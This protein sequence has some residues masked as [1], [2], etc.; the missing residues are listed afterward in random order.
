MS[1]DTRRGKMCATM[2]AMTGI[3]AHEIENAYQQAR[4]IPSTPMQAMKQ[5][6]QA[7]QMMHAYQDL[8]ISPPTH[9]VRGPKPESHA[10]HAA[11][12][13][14]L[15]THRCP[16]CKRFMGQA[17]CQNCPGIRIIA[18][19]DMY[20]AYNGKT[21]IMEGATH[22]IDRDGTITID[23]MQDGVVVRT[24]ATPTWNTQVRINE[25]VQGVGDPATTTIPLHG[26]MRSVGVWEA[27]PQQQTLTFVDDETGEMYIQI[28]TRTDTEGTH[29]I[30]DVGTGGR[31]ATTQTCDWLDD[32]FM[33][34]YRQGQD[35]WD[36]AYRHVEETDQ[37]YQILLANA[38][39]H[40]VQSRD[41]AWDAF[42]HA[43][44]I[45]TQHGMQYLADGTRDESV[46]F[47]SVYEDLHADATG[48]DLA[49]AVHTCPAA[50]AV[51][52]RRMREQALDKLAQQV[53]REA[54]SMPQPVQ[55][56][57][58]PTEW[59][60][61]QAYFHEGHIAS[62]PERSGDLP[63]W[64][65]ASLAHQA[66]Q[67]PERL[68]PATVSPMPAVIAHQGGARNRG[69]PITWMRLQTPEVRQDIINANA[70]E[71]YNEQRLLDALGMASRDEGRTWKQDLA[72]AE[73]QYRESISHDS[74]DATATTL[75]NEWERLR[76]LRHRMPYRWRA[77][78]GSP[79]GRQE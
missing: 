26:G 62:N 53:A 55:P 64:F 77:P 43:R 3:P 47:D 52:T 16:N 14:I 24:I 23:R 21:Q 45:A 31:R 60:N 28:G 51:Q 29:A 5:T 61:V 54:E 7:H 69:N 4:F 30:M 71:P 40:T 73:Q 9:S 42:A 58:N 27:T 72:H 8:G 32:R 74:D 33:A 46:T 12:Y 34:A 13:A 44:M 48:Y 2:S 75:V 38:E 76:N 18:A 65:D 36:A 49:K 67:N 15:D 37:V 22:T 70:G 25:Y 11:M 66:T 39:S 20:A 6:V 10:G 35:Q 57:G 63:I 41:A 19:V 17:G 50:V 1:C 79:E 68:N 78:T 59:G 56:F